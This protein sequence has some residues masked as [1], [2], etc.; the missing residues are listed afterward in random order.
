MVATLVP[1]LILAAFLFRRV[2]RDNREA[3]DRRLLETA[4]AEMAVVEAELSGSI[5]AL[6]ALA[7]SPQLAANDLDAF[8]LEAIAFLKTQTSWARVTLA[9]PDGLQVVNTGIAPGE[10]LPAIADRESF[11]G[12]FT[13]GTPK[14]GNLTLAN[15]PL[16]ELV[17]PIRV[18]VLH[19]GRA[20]Y[21][22]TAVITPAAMVSIIQQQA[23]SSDEAARGLVDRVGA[24]VA[25]TPD[26][27]AFIG[28]QATAELMARR[29]LRE[30]V[31]R[32]T[33][34]DGRRVYSAFTTGQLSNWT[35][36][37][38]IPESAVDA[39]PNRSVLILS[40]AGGGLLLVG[41][42]F[43]IL[44]SRRI[45]NDIELAAVAADDLVSGH[46]PAMPRS[47]VSEVRR[48]SVALRRSASLLDAREKERDEFIARAN[49]AREVAENANRAKDEFLA[50]LGHELRNPLA[51]A[52]TALHLMRLRGDTSGQRE[53]EIIERQVRHLARLVDDLLDVSRA[54]AG[55]LDIRRHPFEIIHAIETA[56]EIASPLITSRGH[57]LTV[58]VASTGLVVSGDETRL[59]QV[60]GN[61]LNNAAKHSDKQGRII[62][63]ARSEADAIVVECSDTGLGI[64]DE[65]LPRVFDHF[66]QGAQ[67]IERQQG[68][69]GL[70][71]AVVKTLVEL[72]GGTV[73]ARSAGPGKGSTFTVRLPKATI[74]VAAS[75]EDGPPA[76]ERSVGRRVLVV[77]DN[78]D[79]AEMLADML[80]L[81]GF[82][83]AVAHDGMAALRLNDEFHADVAILDIGLPAMDGLELGRRLRATPGGAAIRLVA[84]TGYGQ[85]SDV[86]ASQAAG[87]DIHL[88]KPVVAATL[89]EAINGAPRHH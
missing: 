31:Y 15:R 52:L 60:F 51:P 7:L 28:Q 4:R 83:V 69:L 87:F 71:L 16:R 55:R 48:L 14:V 82:T 24:V 20:V 6:Q 49:S 44:I 56:V 84:M 38:A 19:D 8:R 3:L 78:H 9:G 1:A 86:E 11:D 29:V 45:S 22:L 26:P 61:L 39:F 18:P 50:T 41:G 32:D 89:F 63:S 88:V 30:G 59:A 36:A 79:A 66:S 81:S 40:S 65:L 25:R 17:I 46:E 67:S 13:D 27:D 73:A 57:L 75:D 34:L 43:A 70:G 2:A 37:V 33:A 62:V 35:A 5:R 54:R 58:D 12:V 85:R 10:S 64:D 21:A 23:L 76:Q 74:E 42:L 47:S 77:D 53:R 72:H 80:R 68:G